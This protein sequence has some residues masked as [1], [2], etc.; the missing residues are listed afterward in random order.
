MTVW[1]QLFTHLTRETRKLENLVFNRLCRLF[2]R[3]KV[4]FLRD[5][6]GHEVD[7]LVTRRDGYDTYQVCQYLTDENA[8]REFRPLLR[9]QK[10]D[11]GAR[12]EKNRFFLV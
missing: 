6:R 2:G 1:N 9:L 8:S 3:D 5:E 10:N 4:Y 7:F 12:G 11:T